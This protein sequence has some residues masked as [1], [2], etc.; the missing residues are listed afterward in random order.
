M[1]GNLKYYVLAVVMI[2]ILSVCF[3]VFADGGGSDINAFLNSYGYEISNRPIEHSRIIIPKPLDAVFAAYNEIQKK[4]GFDLTDYEGKEG[5]R[6]TY[7]IKN[8]PGGIDGVRANVIVAEGKIIGGDICTVRLDGF[9][10]EI[11]PVKDISSSN[12]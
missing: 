2:V 4:A 8:Y 11:K 7:E 12:Y 10:H 1:N 6:Y 3:I 5:M 9:M